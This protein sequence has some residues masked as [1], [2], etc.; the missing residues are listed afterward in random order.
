MTSKVTAMVIKFILT[1]LL[2]DLAIMGFVD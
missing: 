2:S 1:N